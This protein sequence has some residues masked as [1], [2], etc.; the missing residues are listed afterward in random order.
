MKELYVNQLQ[1]LATQTSLHLAAGWFLTYP[2]MG[3]VLRA[4][5]QNFILRLPAALTFAMFLNI[6]GANW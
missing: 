5:A 3:P 6:Q 2:L 4:Q 1:H